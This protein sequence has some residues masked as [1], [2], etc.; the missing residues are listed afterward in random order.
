MNL[1]RVGNRGVNLENMTAYAFKEHGDEFYDGTT[2]PIARVFFDSE[3][4]TTFRGEDALK[5]HSYL[6]HN[7]ADLDALWKYEQNRKE[8]A[9][10]V[11]DDI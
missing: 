10:N 5:L 4:Y 3:N 2:E 11:R 7:S 8:K 9:S 6:Q 1:L